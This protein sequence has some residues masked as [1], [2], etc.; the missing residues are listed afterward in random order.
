MG[1]AEWWIDFG[2]ARR[3]TSIRPTTID[4]LGIWSAVSLLLWRGSLLEFIY[5]ACWKA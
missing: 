5:D 4:K 3:L 2:L 1:L